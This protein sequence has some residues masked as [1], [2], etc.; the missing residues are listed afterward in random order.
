M[1]TLAVVEFLTLDGV[2]QSLGSADED[3]DGYW[4]AGCWCR[5]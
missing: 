2:M 5:R 1:R 3:R 4:A